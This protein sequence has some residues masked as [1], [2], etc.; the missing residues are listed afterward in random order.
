MFMH[1]LYTSIHF[2]DEYNGVS[3]YGVKRIKGV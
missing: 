3:M 2:V 1:Y